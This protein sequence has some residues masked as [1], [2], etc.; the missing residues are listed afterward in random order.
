MVC[1]ADGLPRRSRSGRSVP[2][3][4]SDGTSSCKNNLD[5]PSRR[6]PGAPAFPTGHPAP[7]IDRRHSRFP[8]RGSSPTPPQPVSGTVRPDAAPVPLPIPVPAFGIVW[9]GS[10]GSLLTTGSCSARTARPSFR[11]AHNSAP[12]PLPHRFQRQFPEDTPFRSHRWGADAP[13][14]ASERHKIQ[15]PADS[16]APSGVLPLW[17][18]CGCI[19]RFRSGPIFPYRPA[20]LPAAP[21]SQSPRPIPAGTGRGPGSATGSHSIQIPCPDAVPRL[22]RSPSASPSNFFQNRP[23]SIGVGVSWPLSPS[24][25]LHSSTVFSAP[26]SSQ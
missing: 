16:P 17:S 8:V 11:P 7:S 14:S 9:D 18:T 13:R 22:G 19:R 1:G 25:F 23:S 15:Y 4:A 12:A 6:N 2:L 26:Q 24:V 20:V 3:S 10:S 5:V 21:L